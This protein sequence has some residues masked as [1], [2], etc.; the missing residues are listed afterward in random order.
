M[1]S[2]LGSL[3]Y[4]PPALGYR[5]IRVVLGALMTAVL[6]AALDQNILATAMPTVVS[7][8][9]GLDHYPWVITAYLLTGTVAM[10]F[11]GRIGDLRGRRPLPVSGP[12]C[13][14]PV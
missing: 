11:Y 13:K 2:R 6:L 7:E 3:D 4:R 14:R 9:G 10:P 1:T 8:L 12:R 5:Q